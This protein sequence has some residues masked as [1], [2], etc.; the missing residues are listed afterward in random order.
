MQRL[1]RQWTAPPKPDYAQR[2]LITRFIKRGDAVTLCNPPASKGR[3][4]N[5]LSELKY[6]SNKKSLHNS[7]SDD[8]YIHV[9][10]SKLDH[11]R[12]RNYFS[13]FAAPKYFFLHDL[14]PITHAEYARP[15]TYEQHVRRVKLISSVA[16]SVM[17][18]SNYTRDVFLW[19]LEKNGLRIPST[20]VLP[21]G[22][23]H[24]SFADDRPSFD[25]P[26]FMYVSTIE[27]RKNH[28][29][30]LTLWREMI[31]EYGKS[32]PMLFLVGKRGWECEAAVDLLERCR[33]L[34]GH[35]FELGNISND[36]LTYLLNGA[37]GCV[38]PSFIEGF[39]LSL[40]E[41][42]KAGIPTIASD[43]QVHRE[44]A[45]ESA[46]YCS[47]IDGIRW[48]KEIMKLAVN[49]AQLMRFSKGNSD[50][51]FSWEEHFKGFQKF[52]YRCAAR[53]SDL[54]AS[55]SV[56]ISRVAI[57]AVGVLKRY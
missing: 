14:I 20:I 11:K 46:I 40:V 51:K 56:F 39:S 42:I 2:E 24:M 52:D 49:Q 28:A 6:L 10:H 41:A 4:E 43:I 3:T 1:E 48:K 25:R 33:Q 19:Y 27:G 15:Q 50:D 54:D 31:E 47:P 38:V 34:K 7:S 23:D 29:F 37:T 57:Q 26:Y 18:N 9:S 16:A 44:V 53:V 35:V 21:L 5:W 32:A 8:V 17:V 30:L 55:I 36:S 12:A 45:C 22:V 13:S